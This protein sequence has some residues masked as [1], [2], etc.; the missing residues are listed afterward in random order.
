[1]SGDK[2][3]RELWEGRKLGAVCP[4]GNPACDGTDLLHGDWCYKAAHESVPPGGPSDEQIQYGLVR[5]NFT[6]KTSWVH[7]GWH[8]PFNGEKR[9][10][11]LCAKTGIARM[12]DTGDRVCEKCRRMA[13]EIQ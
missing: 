10:T 9:L 3:M 6:R 7:Y 4:D 13:G 1:M 12:D 2:A 8:V 5:V 11:T